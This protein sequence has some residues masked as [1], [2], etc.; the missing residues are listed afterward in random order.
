MQGCQF[1]S[2]PR[3]KMISEVQHCVGNNEIKMKELIVRL[4]LLRSN[5]L[6]YP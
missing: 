6:L 5:D 3:I 2:Q 4:A 1:T